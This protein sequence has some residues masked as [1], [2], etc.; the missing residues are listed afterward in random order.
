MINIV[1]I[2]GKILKMSTSAILTVA[3]VSTFII[4]EI[5]KKMS[6]L[7]FSSIRDQ[8]KPYLD[9][10]FIMSIFFCLVKIVVAVFPIAS[11]KH[12]DW[13]ARRSV[14]IRLGNL[15]PEE[16]G[17]LLCYIKDKTRSRSLNIYDGTI[18]GLI[19]ARIIY[20]SSD[21][22][23]AG[24]YRAS[25]SHNITNIAWDYLNKNPEKVGLTLIDGSFIEK[26]KTP[27]D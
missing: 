2:A 5:D 16:R 15:T 17:I 3:V 12:T 24:A 11:S 19:N 10:V 27:T 22:G 18:Q 13:R 21:V 8:G 25:F 9:I 23:S 7:D 4:F 26:T 20:R 14:E 1:S 6:I